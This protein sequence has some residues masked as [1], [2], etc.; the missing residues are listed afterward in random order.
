M[1]LL[2]LLVA[3]RFIGIRSVTFL[4]LLLLSRCSLHSCGELLLLLL[5]LVFLPPLLLRCCP[6]GP[7]SVAV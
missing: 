6:C 3:V 5:L 2:L 7:V 1:L 4:M